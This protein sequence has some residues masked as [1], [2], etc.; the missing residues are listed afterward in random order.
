MVQRKPV[1]PWLD[2]LRV[3]NRR[4]R[5]EHGP[6]DV[7]AAL[8]FVGPIHAD[9]P[10]TLAREVVD[11]VRAR[12]RIL[13]SAFGYGMPK[14]LAEIV[15]QRGG[16]CVSHAVLATVILR[17]SGIPTRLV[18]ESV[19]TSFSLLRLPAAVARAP[20]GP[21][22]NGHVWCEVLLGD[23]WIPVDAELGIFGTIEWLA[24]RLA[25]PV[26]ITAVG[27]PV[28]ERWQFPLRI[29]RLASDGTPG[30]DVSAL[31]LVDRLN[32]ALGNAASLPDAWTA[33]VTHFSRSFDWEG[34]PGLRLLGERRVLRTMA[35]AR[36]RFSPHLV[37]ALG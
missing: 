27:L 22:L 23:D 33:G 6:E 17:Q 32:E 18:S 36:T 1:D 21:T 29:R 14:T 19:Y 24:A 31:Y 15:A 7:R 5:F 3:L 10:N 4:M 37:K 20:I 28:R 26:V 12:M 8:E 2:P 11:R 30:E 35:A 25:A 34:R 9:D 16:N 13:P